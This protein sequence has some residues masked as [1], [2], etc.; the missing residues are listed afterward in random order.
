MNASIGQV[1]NGKRFAVFQG[2]VAYVVCV[3]PEFN[4]LDAVAVV[5]ADPSHSGKSPKDQ[6]EKAEQGFGEI[7]CTYTEQS[8]SRLCIAYCALK[9]VLNVVLAKGT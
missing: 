8:V 6:V 4:L 1:D 3:I 5:L 7:V 9:F 2:S